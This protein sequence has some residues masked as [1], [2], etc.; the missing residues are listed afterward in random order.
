[1]GRK[2]G[3]IR[4]YQPGDD[5]AGVARLLQQVC[6]FDGSVAPWS[7]AELARR[8]SRQAGGSRVAT[9]SNGTIIGAML[10]DDV[11]SVRSEL[12]LAVNPAFRRQELGTALL[13]E[14]PAHRRLLCTSRTSVGGAAQVLAGAG[15]HER[16]RR[17]MMR[18]EAVGIKPLPIEDGRI[19]VDDAKD[20]RRA[21]IAL[22]AAIGEDVE[23]DLDLLRD[24]LS[25]ERAAVVYLVT[26][27]PDGHPVD[28]GVCLLRPSPQ[29][30]KGERTAAGEPIVGLISHVGLMRKIRGK[31]F[32]RALVR[33]GMRQAQ[34]VGFRFVEVHADTRRAAAV[35]LYEREGFE[36]VDEQVLWMRRE[37]TSVGRA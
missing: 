35:E 21:M 13:A 9:S 2:S 3:T 27:G 31:G 15:F 25:H 29:A 18:R 17:L 8:L 1:M 5:D 10:V 23:D 30:K 34:Q 6:S 14:A 20:V 36:T 16:F 4:S 22:T 33:A 11:G 32:S 28:A 37:D 24:I 26:T 19:V 7:E 12:V